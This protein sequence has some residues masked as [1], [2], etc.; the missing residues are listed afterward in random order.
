MSQLVQISKRSGEIPR[1]AR[2]KTP[3]VELNLEPGEYIASVSLKESVLFTSERK[4]IDWRW[5]AYVVH[6]CK[7]TST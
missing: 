1:V 3:I 5:T 6:P 2:G 7:G 4:T